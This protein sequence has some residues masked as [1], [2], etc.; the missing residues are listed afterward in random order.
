MLRPKSL[1]AVTGLTLTIAM[2][3]FLLISLS[4]ITFYILAPVSRQAADDL[5]ALMVLSAQTWVELPPQT[6]PDFEQELLARHHLRVALAETEQEQE[7]QPFDHPALYL[8]FLKDALLR[9]TGQ[10]IRIMIDQSSDNG[11]WLQT[12]LPVAERV[13]RVSFQSERLGTHFPAATLLILTAGTLVILL[14]SLLLVR[15]I[16]RSLARLAEA[17]ARIGD[18]QPL[19][20]L[21]ETGPRELAALARSFNRM[22]K[23]VKDLLENRTTLLA[24]IS[25]DLRTPISRMG[26]ALEMLP[27]QPDPDLVDRLRQDLAEMERLI[28]QTLELARGL[29]NQETELLDIR[30]PIDTLV[31]RYIQGGARLEWTPGDSCIIRVVPLALQ[32]VLTNLLDNAIRFSDP[33]QPVEIDY[34]CGHGELVIRVLD[35]GPGIPAEQ[36]ESVFRPFYRLEGSRSRST[37]GSGLG[38]AITRQLCD[39]NRWEIELAP[40]D[41][42][43][44]E[45]RLRIP[46][47]YSKTPG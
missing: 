17:T 33:K 42:G 32:R 44:T 30:E 40:R 19:T 39:T 36:V 6:R 14:T 7:Q 26:L 16:T 38:L 46:R 37:G 25:H 35:R 47:N 21:P 5:A 3:V 29:D 34:R 13:L 27:P 11:D 22:E 4:A 23:Q 20:P 10:P 9:R 12:D 43:G 2:G 8:R 18:S 28:G 45:A 41:G 31:S 24:G 1:F 15:R